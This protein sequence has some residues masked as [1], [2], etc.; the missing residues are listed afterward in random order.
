MTDVSI[1]IRFAAD[2]RVR[3]YPI[4]DDEDSFQLGERLHRLCHALIK[5]Q[6]AL[7]CAIGWHEHHP[8]R[9]LS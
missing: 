6:D 4:L 8:G 9:C 5:S 3:V 7:S 2:G 1:L